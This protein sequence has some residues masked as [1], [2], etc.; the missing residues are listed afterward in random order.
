[1]FTS[2]TGTSLTIFPPTVG[3]SVRVNV[4]AAVVNYLDRVACA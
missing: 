3:R 1:M 4:R 2:G